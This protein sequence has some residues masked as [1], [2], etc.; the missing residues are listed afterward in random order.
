MKG[1]WRVNE[2]QV[3]GKWRM[4]GGQVEASV[5]QMKDKPKKYNNN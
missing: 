5:E 2:G 3:E 4:N 1:K